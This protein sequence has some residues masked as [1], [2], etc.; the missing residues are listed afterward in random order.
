VEDLNVFIA[1]LSELTEYIMTTGGFSR[2]ILFVDF[3]NNLLPD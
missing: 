1:Q 3:T 2:H